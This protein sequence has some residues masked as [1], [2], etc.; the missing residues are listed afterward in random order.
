MFCVPKKLY[1]K[2]KTFMFDVHVHRYYICTSAMSV[3][4]NNFGCQ[5][6]IILCK[7]TIPI[8]FD[9]VVTT[10]VTNKNKIDYNDGMVIT[11]RK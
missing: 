7:T 8:D 4:C 1:L 9:E 5:S 10:Y 6:W 11:N 2:K 3:Y